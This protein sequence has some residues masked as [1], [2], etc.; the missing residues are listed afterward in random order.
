MTTDLQ[1]RHIIALANCRQD[2]GFLAVDLNS[3]ANDA[4]MY[5]YFISW[6]RLLLASVRLPPIVLESERM[7]L[8]L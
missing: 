2:F 3:V 4:F 5:R 1:E 8:L 6:L 7:V